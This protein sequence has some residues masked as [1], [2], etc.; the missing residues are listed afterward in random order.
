[1]NW[2]KIEFSGNGKF[3]KFIKIGGA[4]YNFIILLQLVYIGTIEGK[5]IVRVIKFIK[6]KITQTRIKPVAGPV[7]D[8]EDDFE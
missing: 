1:M 3:R 7:D 6:K 4:L 5:R 8:E 2:S